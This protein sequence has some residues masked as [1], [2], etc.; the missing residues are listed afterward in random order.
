MYNSIILTKII[1]VDIVILSTVIYFNIFNIFI[2][3]ILYSLVP[4]DEGTKYFR[5]IFNKENPSIS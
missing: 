2:K 1:E 5:F 3:N 4:F